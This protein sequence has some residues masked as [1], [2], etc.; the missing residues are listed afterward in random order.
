MILPA[1]FD[2]GLSEG[3]AQPPAWWRAKGAR[4]A[5]AGPWS[6][7]DTAAEWILLLPSGASGP[8]FLVAPNHFVIRKYNNSVAYALS[9]GLLADRID[10]A[11]PLVTPWPHETSRSPSPTAWPPRAPS[12]PRATIRA[13]WTG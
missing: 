9:V 10:G 8:A 6:A 4:P 13:R 2:Y 3:P 12:P 5:D 7:G 11:A 1:G